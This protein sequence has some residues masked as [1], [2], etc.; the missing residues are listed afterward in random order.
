MPDRFWLKD[1]IRR[2]VIVRGEL[3]GA[4]DGDSLYLLLPGP[5]LCISTQ[6]PLIH[7]AGR[8]SCPTVGAF[9]HHSTIFSDFIAKRK[10]LTYIGH[11]C[12]HHYSAFTRQ[13]VPQPFDSVGHCS[14]IEGNCIIEHFATFSLTINWRQGTIR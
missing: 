1:T 8:R 6:T 13:V 3:C 10:S 5:P 2:A 14:P 4:F 9:V 12:T 7:H 11:K